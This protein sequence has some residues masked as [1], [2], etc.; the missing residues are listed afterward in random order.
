[1]NE[2]I[3]L[4]WTRKLYWMVPLVLALLMVGSLLLVGAVTGVA[5]FIYTLF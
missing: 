4:L 1:V 2:L 3:T 5:P